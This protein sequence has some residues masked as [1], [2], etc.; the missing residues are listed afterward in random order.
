MSED[1]GQQR[2]VPWTQRLLAWL[3]Q[4]PHRPGTAAAVT[5]G[6]IG[7]LFGGVIGILLASLVGFV[8]WHRRSGMNLQLKPPGVLSQTLPAVGRQLA[9]MV[10]FLPIASFHAMPSGHS[11]DTLVK[12]ASIVLA[13]PSNLWSARA[14]DPFPGIPVVVLAAM[15]LMFWGLWSPRRTLNKV[16]LLSGFT[17][18]L[19]SPTLGALVTGDPGLH[20]PFGHLRVGFYVALAGVLAMLLPPRLAAMGAAPVAPAAALLVFWPNPTHW[21]ALF[22]LGFE[23][24]HHGAAALLSG[25][26]AGALGASLV[27]EEAEQQDGGG[28]FLDL[29]HPAGHSPNAFTTGWVFAARCILNPG[30]DRERD[31][32]DKVK[33]SGSGTF[34]PAQGANSRPHFSGPG[35]NTI[36][37][38]YKSKGIAITKEYAVSA[39]APAGYASIGS[40]A[41]CPSDAH[42]C[43]ACPHATT[44]EVQTGSPNVL[45]DGKP[46]ARVG[47]TGTHAACCGPNTFAITGGDA[48]VLINGRPAA[49]AGSPTKHCGGL[50]QIKG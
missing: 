20:L 41:E 44:G 45:V 14:F 18:Y 21:L 6:V 11:P 39:V 26:L 22:G 32:S 36:K 23:A 2:A 50:G 29:R 5:G 35:A 7:T 15:A 9:A 42:G 38:T 16:A 19:F 30:T 10:F 8:L 12:Y 4:M 46:A 48:R 37:L 49:K 27:N 17:L 31:V 25:A 40:L 1:S 28:V 24:T 47:D 43:P 34:T 13:K 3:R 33:W